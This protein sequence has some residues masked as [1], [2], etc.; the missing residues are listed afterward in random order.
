MKWFESKYAPYIFLNGIIFSIF[1][2]IIEWFSFESITNFLL[3]YL[4]TPVVVNLI[5]FIYIKNKQKK[6]HLNY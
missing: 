3:F 2:F 1:L 6:N 5:I 4:G